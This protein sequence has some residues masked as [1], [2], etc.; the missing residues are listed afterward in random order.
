MNIRKL[1]KRA[2]GKESELSIAL[3][4]IEKELVFRGF[5]DDTPDLSMCG[6]CEI[7]LVY[8]GREI[9]IDKVIE[10]MENVGYISKSDFILT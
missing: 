9:Y 4:A 10:L 3:Q 2:Q 1:V 6:G 8:Q 7:I 5:Q